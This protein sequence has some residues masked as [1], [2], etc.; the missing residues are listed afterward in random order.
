MN[1]EGNGNM[2]DMTTTT[3][4]NGTEE[5]TTMKDALLEQASS[6]AK[7]LL[8]QI[9]A[10]LQLWQ[11]QNEGKA[12]QVDDIMSMLKPKDEFDPNEPRILS[13]KLF[14]GRN[15]QSPVYYHD[16]ST[17]SY[18]DT[19]GRQWLNERP[20]LCDHLNERDLNTSDVFDAIL[21]GVMDD[22]D[23]GALEK[24]NLIDDRSKQLWKKLTTLADQTNMMMKSVETEPSEGEE[25]AASPRPTPPAAEGESSS[26][27]NPFQQI[28][29]G[30]GVVDSV[31][32]AP[33]A[34]GE[35]MVEKIMST[36][37]QK[38][39]V[40]ANEPVD[41]EHL[42]RLIQQEIALSMGEDPYDMFGEDL[43][44]EDI[45]NHFQNLQFPQI[46]A[47]APAQENNTDDGVHQ[48]AMQR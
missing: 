3:Q 27:S 17:S 47:A 2:Q 13:F 32:S 8:S 33:E 19:H 35:N 28:K 16:P 7:E 39:P 5:Q 37:Q 36:A 14:H 15:P 31:P 22:E 30:A 43:T 40:V 24:M 18:F 25:G 46:D 38:Q 23:Y 6:K 20:P 29:S 9:K 26:G 12:P 45:A 44:S 34:A 21:H 42:Q 1:E 41:Y 10:A 48:F 11:V 4:S